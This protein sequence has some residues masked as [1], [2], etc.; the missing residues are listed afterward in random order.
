MFFFATL[1]QHEEKGRH[2]APPS[3]FLTTFATLGRRGGA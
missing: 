1:L 2:N 3:V